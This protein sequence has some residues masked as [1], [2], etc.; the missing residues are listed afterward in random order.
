M[1]L[2][3][4]VGTVLMTANVAYALAELAKSAVAFA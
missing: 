2:A 4:V 1:K 3:I